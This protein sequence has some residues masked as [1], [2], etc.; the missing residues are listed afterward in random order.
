MPDSMS[1]NSGNAGARIAFKR[2]LLGLTQAELAEAFGVSRQTVQS[3]ESGEQKP[4]AIV[5]LALD[6]L[7]AR[8]ATAD[9]DKLALYESFLEFQRFSSR[10]RRRSTDL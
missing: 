4:K 2:S 1:S 6:G 10:R 7:I 9:A 3:Y 8:S 5:E